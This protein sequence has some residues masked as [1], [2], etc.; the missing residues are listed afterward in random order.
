VVVPSRFEPCGLTQLAA[1]RYGAPPV[2]ARTGGLADTVID[3]NPVAMAAGCATGVQVAPGRADALAAGLRR[4][5]ALLRDGAAWRGMQAR[6]MATDVSWGPS[7]RRYAAL[8]RAIAGRGAALP[9]GAEE[10]QGKDG[11][12]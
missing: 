6:A 4:A 3:A 7:A 9:V 11:A 8:L 12:P 1:L 2:V 5:L 10:T